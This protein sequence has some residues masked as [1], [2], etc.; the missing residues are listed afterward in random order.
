MIKV[1]S[2]QFNY[3][4]EDQIHFPYSI[5]MI[6]GYIKTKEDLKN[7]FNFQKTFVFREKVDEYI[8]Q[9]T[10]SDLLLCSCYVWNWEITNYLAKKVKEIN[11]KCLIIF[12]GPHVPEDTTGFFDEHPYVNILA[13]GEG[14]YILENLL[15][16]Y[17]TDKNYLNVKGITTKDFSTPGQE[18]I[19]DLDAIPS[20]Y[21]TNLV[22]DLVEKVP[23]VTWICSWETNRGC[24]YMCTFCDWGSATF[25]KL[26]KFSEERLYKD[27]EWFGENKIPFVDCCDANFGIYQDRDLVLARKMKEMALEKGY[28]QKMAVSWAKNSSEKIIPIA[29]ELQD[30]GILGAVTLAVQSLDDDVLEIIKR[31][32]IK[33]NEFSELTATFRDHEIPTYSEVIRGLPGETVETFKRGL[34]ILSST[35]IGTVNIYH[36]MILPN[37][38]MNHPA[39]VEKFKIKKIRS[40]VM[41]QHSSIHKRAIPEYEYIVTETSTFNLEDLKTMYN[42]SWAFSTLHK[43]GLLEH[44]ASYYKRINKLSYMKFFELVFKFCE[45]VSDSVF[46]Q[47]FKIVKEYRDNGYSGNGWDHQDPLLGEIIW[48]MEEASWL[49]MA[50]HKDKLYE[51]VTNLVSF[52]ENEM[53]FKTS[54]K[55]LDDLIK[56]QIF[57]QNTREDQM[58][59]KSEEFEYDWKKFFSEYESLVECKKCYFYKNPVIES[60]P[61]KWSYK[62]AWYGRRS[63]KYKCHSEHLKQKNDQ[64]SDYQITENIVTKQ[65]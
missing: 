47:E 62:V 34:E 17:I 28:L 52:I 16:T 46:A 18:R 23:G 12:G 40:P 24:P 48:P 55:I 60:D 13:H 59:I 41:L 43:F 5:A 7:E 26:R 3:Q 14:E 45:Q 27:I 39:Y 54:K 25:T 32:N 37:A 51:S 2:A 19:N 53:N 42:Y 58:E 31:A 61:I 11:P 21:T 20:V 63:E 56:F 49:R 22:W 30:G 10:D 6:V 35:K 1:S 38:P 36:C 29:K 50:Y 15:R 65:K 4:Y 33:F 57:V 9:C 8:K 44:V 64:K